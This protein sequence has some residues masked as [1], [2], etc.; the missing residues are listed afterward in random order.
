MIHPDNIYCCS[1]AVLV[2]T[3]EASAAQVAE[4][5][6]DA[7]GRPDVVVGDLADLASLL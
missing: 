2:L 1:L 6:P 4:M 5:A 7:P 3:G